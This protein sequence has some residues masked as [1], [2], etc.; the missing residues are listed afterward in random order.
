MST[1]KCSCKNC[2]YNAT[3]HIDVIPYYQD[4]IC[5]IYLCDMHFNLCKNV[6]DN[7]MINEI[8]GYEKDDFIV[9]GV[10]GD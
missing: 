6:C 5:P 1:K 10:D 7:D 8:L 4:G 9:I 2:E 3:K